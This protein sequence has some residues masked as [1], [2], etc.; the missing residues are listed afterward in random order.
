MPIC[1]IPLKT[2]IQEVLKASV[3]GIHGCKKLKPKAET[4]GSQQNSGGEI[5]EDLYNTVEF[6]V[7][8]DESI[9]EEENDVKLKY[10]ENF[11]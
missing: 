8:E 6:S 11:G 10:S 4:K 1:I 2:N 9:K 7:T 5:K 3:F